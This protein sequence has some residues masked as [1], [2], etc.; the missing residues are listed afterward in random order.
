MSISDG[1]LAVAVIFLFGTFL[2]VPISDAEAGKECKPGHWHHGGSSPTPNKSKKAAIREAI[3]SWA[4]FTAWEYGR[5]WAYFRLAADRKTTCNK[6]PGRRWT[7]A[8]EG[9]PCKRVR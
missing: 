1:R 4:G 9:R 3:N 6:Y 7:C 2:T 5:E 8:V